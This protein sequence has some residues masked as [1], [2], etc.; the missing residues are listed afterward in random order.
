M[1]IS[2][3]NLEIIA[4]HQCGLSYGLT[5][6]ER[7]YIYTVLQNDDVD[8]RKISQINT[9]ERKPYCL[10]LKNFSILFFFFSFFINIKRLRSVYN[11]AQMRVRRFY[12]LDLDR[13]SDNAINNANFP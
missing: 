12:R 9:K 10:L 13:E 8:L 5:I 7:T 4:T 1:F 6:R 11:E 2:R 3:F